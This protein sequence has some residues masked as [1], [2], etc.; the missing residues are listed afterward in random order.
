MPFRR[1]VSSTT[2]ALLTA[3]GLVLNGAP[4]LAARG[5]DGPDIMRTKIGS[6]QVIALHDKDFS[7]PNDGSVFGVD[8]GPKAVAKTLKAAGAPT[9]PI[10][11][12]DDALLADMGQRKVL[13]DTGI[14]GALIPSLKLAGYTPADITDILITHTHHDHIGGLVSH[15][16]LTFPNATIHLSE[17]EWAWMQKQP[18]AAAIVKV[19]T[20]KVETFTAG[21]AVTPGIT[22]V[23]LPGH[24]PGH[25]GYRISSDGDSLLDIGDSAHSAIV[26]VAQPQW[27]I[28]FDADKEQGRKTRLAILDE[29]A[30]S[31]ELIFAPHFPFPGIGHVVRTDGPHYKW[32][33]LV[34]PS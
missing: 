15:G 34:P 22:A 19:I 8:A 24:T 33:P 18:Q 30:R 23:A 1:P 32:V 9:D 14:G 28:S 26:S 3:A 12:S 6:V 21:G 31:H 2:L 5:A 10:S 29:A 11:L 27:L 25:S 17:A 7:R 16:G 4:A 13:I 20:P